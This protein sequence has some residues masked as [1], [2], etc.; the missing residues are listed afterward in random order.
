VAQVFR[1]DAV[2]T[3]ALARADGRS[4]GRQTLEGTSC[5]DLAEAAA[6]ILAT[7]ENDGTPGSGLSWPLPP[8][9]SS[10]RRAPASPPD[11]MPSSR[12]RSWD[13]ALGAGASLAP[14][15]FSLALMGS[16]S[17]AP[18]GGPF[19]LLVA[20]GLTGYGTI[21]L[22]NGRV[23]W[24][25][26]A[27]GGGPR[28]SWTTSGVVA[29]VHAGAYASWVRSEG[30]GFVTNRADDGFELALAGSVRLTLAGRGLR[31]WIEGGAWFF[32]SPVLAYELPTGEGA[33][34]PKA[35]VLV[36]AGFLLGP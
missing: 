4:I 36:L 11:P 5:S 15:A 6:V 2:V 30:E 22:P 10:E 16:G 29:A 33:H 14:R 27:L 34:L 20:G 18:G 8:S 26:L 24:T 7:W 25:R 3:V 13:V 12:E 35:G 9:T 21:E 32:P 23:S 31:P 1:R 19:G 28:V 17:F